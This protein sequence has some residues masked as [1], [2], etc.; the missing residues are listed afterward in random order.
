MTH[1]RIPSITVLSRRAIVLVV[2][3][4]MLAASSLTAAAAQGPYLVRDL[5]ADGPSN[6]ASLTAV[7]NRLFFTADDGVTGRELYVS[8]GTSPGTK[9]VKDVRPGRRGSAPRELTPL[10]TRLFFI[11]NDGRNGPGL[12][13]TDGTAA[14][15]K[16]LRNRRPCDGESRSMISHGGKLYLAAYNR[17]TGACNL[18]VSDGTRTGTKLAVRGIAGFYLPVSFQGRIFFVDTTGGVPHSKLWRTNSAVTRI[19]LVKQVNS[20]WINQLTVAGKLL[21]F[22]AAD[23]TG[24]MALWKSDGTSGGTK[25]IVGGAAA[26]LS[27]G[28]LTNLSGNLLFTSFRRIGETVMDRG[29][30]TSDGTAAGTKLVKEL[31]FFDRARL[32]RAGNRVYFTV[33]DDSSG[34]ALW[35]SNGTPTG[36]RLVKREPVDD[37]M[38]AIAGVVYM[39]GGQS[40]LWRSDGSPAGTYEVPGGMRNVWNLT[41]VDGSLFFTGTDPAWLHAGELYR[42]VP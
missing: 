8:D 38:A 19:K 7:S 35:R 3:L 24:E 17:R 4:V 1:R 25:K 11:A 14:G 42:Y 13:V 36:T 10:G 29:L 40:A 20:G 34:S 37:V 2:V 26:P 9:L 6:P 12:Y 16:R 31:L 23:P 28:G 30:W 22:S 21:F 41:A 15:T 18:I 27:P 33:H 5:R 32:T 39:S